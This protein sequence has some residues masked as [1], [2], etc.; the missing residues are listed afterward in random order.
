MKK[1]RDSVLAKKLTI[2]SLTPVAL[3]NV[4]DAERYLDRAAWKKPLAGKGGE[5][6]DK[7]WSK[8]GK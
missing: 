8:W 4:S 5:G 6:W 2:L 1:L 7:G 3:P